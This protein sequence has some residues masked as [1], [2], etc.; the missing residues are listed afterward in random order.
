MLPGEVRVEGHS[1]EI[2]V[3]QDLSKMFKVVLLIMVRTWKQ[4]KWPL[5]DIDV[6]DDSVGT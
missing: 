6:M 3:H 2:W 5:Q 4:P 1:G